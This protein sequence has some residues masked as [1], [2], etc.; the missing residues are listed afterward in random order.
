MKAVL[1]LLALR[2]AVA[3]TPRM[4]RWDDEL[5][6]PTRLVEPVH[7][8]G[9]IAALNS[10]NPYWTAG[11]NARFEGL[12]LRDAKAL[13]G[14]L[15]ATADTLAS[16]ET[17]G[18]KTYDARSSVTLPT[19]FDWRTDPR[20]KGCPSLEEIRDQSNCGS[21][22]AFGSVEAMTDRTC[23]QSNGTKQAHLAA[24]DVTS[25]CRLCGMGCDGG[26]PVAAYS[27]FKRTGV[28]TGGQF[29]DKSMCYSY[30]LAPCAHHVASKTYPNCTGM[31]PTPKCALTG[32]NSA[33]CPDKTSIVWHQDKRM[34]ATTCVE[35]PIP[36]FSMSCLRLS[37]SHFQPSF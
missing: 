32:S 13:M 23:I 15:N 22:W 37:N 7:T 28:V 36:N 24:E 1:I 5:T 16:I 25:C 34:G 26:I 17:D 30:R 12:T 11:K 6:D 18:V 29:G 19:D 8:D 35:F 33:A 14:V 21:C 2:T 20:A 10:E 9:K 4:A 27:Y 31:K 3:S